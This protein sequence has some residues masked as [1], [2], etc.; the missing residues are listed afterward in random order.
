MIKQVAE[1]GAEE[2]Q[3]SGTLGYV[4]NFVEESRLFS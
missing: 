4:P 1:G 2:A 3:E